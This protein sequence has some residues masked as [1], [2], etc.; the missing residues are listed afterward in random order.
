MSYSRNVG[1]KCGSTDKEVNPAEST[2]TTPAPFGWVN[3]QTGDF[4]L[5]ADS[6]AVD[7]GDPADK[8]ATDRDGKARTGTPEAGAYE[9]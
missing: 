6:V 9:R 7:A 1:Q 5:K 3:P 2:R 8:P 4:H